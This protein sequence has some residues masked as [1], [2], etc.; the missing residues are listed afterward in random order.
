MDE[1]TIA[2]GSAATIESLGATPST[3]PQP[4]AGSA[5]P[6]PAARDELWIPL[7][8]LVLLGLSIEWAVYHR[9]AVTRLRRGFLARLGRQTETA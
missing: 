4:G 2:P 6:R 9:D 3:S 5:E 7:V 1:S 8:L